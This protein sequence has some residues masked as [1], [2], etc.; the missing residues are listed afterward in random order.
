MHCLRPSSAIIM[1]ALRRA[2]LGRGTSALSSA[3]MAAAPPV[4]LSVAGA[5][6]RRPL[7]AAAAALPPP[8]PLH[9]AIVGAGPAGLY[10]ADRLLSRYGDG[11]RVDVLERLPTP[12]GL[13]RSGVAPDHPE[14]KVGEEGSRRFLPLWKRKWVFK[15]C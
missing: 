3:T 6:S 7:A 2:L 13:V 5:A 14:T 9:I 8:P 12:F 10:T 11:V 15:P 4:A 1:L